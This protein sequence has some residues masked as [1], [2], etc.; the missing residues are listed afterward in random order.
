MH[1]NK[2]IEMQ[3]RGPRCCFFACSTFCCD[4]IPSIHT[5]FLLWTIGFFNTMNRGDGN[6]FWSC[7][8]SYGNT[9]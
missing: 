1:H 4:E 8:N 7:F 9:F 6:G 5:W 2:P 3:Q